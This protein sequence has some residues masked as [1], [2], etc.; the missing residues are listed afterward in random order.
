MIIDLFKLDGRILTFKFHFCQFLGTFTPSFT[1]IIS[2]VSELNVL[3]KNA[4]VVKNS[5]Y[6]NIYLSILNKY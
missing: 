4:K 1:E 5:L 2:E 6:M 3:C